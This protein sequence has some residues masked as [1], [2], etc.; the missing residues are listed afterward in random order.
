MRLF[1]QRLFSVAVIASLLLAACG[2]DTG[3]SD[4]PTQSR[5]KENAMASA[6]TIEVTSTAFGQGEWIPDKY[7][8]N[9]ENVSPPLAWGELPDGTVQLALICD[10]PDAPG[11]KPWVH[12]VIYRIPS[13]VE[14]LQEEI[15]AEKV[16]PKLGGTCQG[17]NS[18]PDG[19]TIGYRGPAPPPGHGVHRYMFTLYALDTEI[20]LPP[21]ASREQLDA[22]MKDHVLAQGR[23]V[24]T[25]SR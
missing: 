19:Q 15:P 9:G 10:D 6:F 3:G 23:L 21:G 1:T 16:L 14:S 22:A 18:W 4:N 17:L 12:W 8:I 5:K 20:E 25:Y 24:G 7:T 2:C 11:A 13:D